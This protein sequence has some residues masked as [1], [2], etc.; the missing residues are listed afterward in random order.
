MLIYQVESSVCVGNTALGLTSYVSL[1][2]FGK[3]SFIYVHFFYYTILISRYDKHFK[4]HKSVN[5]SL[6]FVDPD[7]PRVHTNSIESQWRVLKRNVLPESGTQ[8]TLYSS[9]FSKYCVKRR[10]LNNVH[11]EFQAFLELIKRVYRLN[12]MVNT[13][14]KDLKPISSNPNTK[15]IAVDKVIQPSTSK[16]SVVKQNL[17]DLSHDSDSN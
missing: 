5:H 14:R 17:P 11:C 10:Y 2:Y 4:E 1:F 9:Y 12:P 6:N 7:D 13:P 8:K 15:P 3:C 16:M